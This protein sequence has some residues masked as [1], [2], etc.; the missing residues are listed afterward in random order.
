MCERVF[1]FFY[2]VFRC[3]FRQPE[4][5]AVV[6]AV[7]GCLAMCSHGLHPLGMQASNLMQG[8]LYT[9]NQQAGPKKWMAPGLLQQELFLLKASMF[10]F[11]HSFQGFKGIMIICW[12]LRNVLSIVISSNMEIGDGTWWT[13][14]GWQM[15]FVYDTGR[16]ILPKHGYC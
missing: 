7:L 11:N 16:R 13:S 12:F 14:N 2:C 1:L 15:H 3:H 9:Q 4:D 5:K 8:L 6:K 10:R